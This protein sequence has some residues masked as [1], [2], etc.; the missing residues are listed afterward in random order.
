MNIFIRQIRQ[1]DRE[2]TDYIQYD[3]LLQQQLSLLFVFPPIRTPDMAP[4]IGYVV[5]FFDILTFEF[6]P[7]NLSLIYF[8]WLI[9]SPQ[10]HSGKHE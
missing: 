4:P 5:V 3:R 2:R 10:R 1:R 8:R 6:S 7:I 9:K